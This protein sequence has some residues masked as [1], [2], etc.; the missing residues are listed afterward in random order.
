MGFLPLFAL[1]AFLNIF[2]HMFQAIT[3][4]LL[5][6]KLRTLKGKFALR[7]YFLGYFEVAFAHK[8]GFFFFD[9]LNFASKT[10]F[11]N[12]FFFQTI[13]FIIQ[14]TL[15]PNQFPW[16]ILSKIN[17]KRSLHLKGK[18][19]FELKLDMRKRFSKNN[20]TFWPIFPLFAQESFLWVKISEQLEVKK[21]NA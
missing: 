8:L 7:V 2:L 5:L 15:T 12:D 9:E 3:A 1:G 4:N 21:I 18:L 17:A 20:Y 10:V 14:S 16:A 13:P 11:I 19:L 6:R